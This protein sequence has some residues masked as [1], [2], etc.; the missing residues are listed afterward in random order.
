MA[1]ETSAVAV[2]ELPCEGGPARLL[3][4][5]REVGQGIPFEEALPRRHG[6]GVPELEEAAQAA[7]SR[8]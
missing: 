5:I 3:E 2:R 6:H 1:H 8:R 7:L 4:L